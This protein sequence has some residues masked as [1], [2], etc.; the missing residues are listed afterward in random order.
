MDSS[1]QIVQIVAPAIEP[2]SLAEMKDFLL[3]E[4]NNDDVFITLLIKA[5]RQNVEK[6]LKRSLITQQWKLTLDQFNNTDYIT[7]PYPF[8]QSINSI[9]TF[10]LDNS[11][12]TVDE[13]IYSLVSQNRIVLNFG[14][15]WPYLLRDRAAVEIT[16][17]AG[18]GDDATDVPESI[19]LAIMLW[20]SAAY[21]QR[22]LCSMPTD[23]ETSLKLHRIPTV[24]RMG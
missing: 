19:R 24:N 23:C 15:Q 22:G 2:V 1:K 11:V 5:V 17:T 20:V 3:V 8:V 9:K 14:A 10:D 18:Y 6:Y 16:Y 4:N 21:Y 13:S 7:L 12:T